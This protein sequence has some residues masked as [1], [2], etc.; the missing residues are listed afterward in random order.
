MGRMVFVDASLR[1]IDVEVMVV[2]M[3]KVLN[4]AECSD[5]RLQA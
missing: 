1:D 5:I 2:L 3:V 4:N